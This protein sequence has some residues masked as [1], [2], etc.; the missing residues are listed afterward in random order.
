MEKRIWVRSGIV[1]ELDKRQAALLKRV[2]EC[3]VYSRC[4]IR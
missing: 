3:I 4:T 1:E 2:H